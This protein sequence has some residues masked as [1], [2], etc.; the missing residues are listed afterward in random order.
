L[1]AGQDG[2]IRIPVPPAVA[3]GQ[4]ADL[5]VLEVARHGEALEADVELTWR[6]EPDVLPE[7]VRFRVRDGK[8]VVPLGSFPEWL[9]AAHIHELSLRLSGDY[10]LA[11]VEWWARTDGPSTFVMTPTGEAQ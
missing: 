9:L 2:L 3:S 11:S 10:E 1:N 6:S 4:D 5:L 8:L 7:P